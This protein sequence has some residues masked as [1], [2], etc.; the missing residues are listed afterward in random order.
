MHRNYH[1]IDSEVHVD[2]FDDRLEIWS[3][4]GMADGTLIQERDIENV[5]STRRNPLIDEI[6]HHLDYVERRGSGFKKI[7]SETANLYGYTDDY[8]PTFSS[9]D[10][11]FRVVFKNMNY[12]LH[13][14]NTHD[15][16]HDAIY[17][18]FLSDDRIIGLVE[19]CSKPKTREEMQDFMGVTN[20]EYFRK[21]YLKPLIKAGQ[22]QMT[23]P[24]KPKSH[25]Q[26]YI[27]AT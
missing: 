1:V 6:F 12:D 13:T 2:M 20:R 27:K 15:N 4:V 11:G 8:K 21:S 3:P 22:I 25:N 16:T 23:L 26:K 10:T 9:T 17:D 24:D 5:P 14:A 18:E 7:R 19:F